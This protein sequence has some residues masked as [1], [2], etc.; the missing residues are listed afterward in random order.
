M[1]VVRDEKDGRRL[2]RRH[3][4]KVVGVLGILLE[5]TQKRL[6][7]DVL[8]NVDLLRK[9]AGFYVTDSVYMAIGQLAREL[10]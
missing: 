5:V 8:P 4:L 9:V 10:K 7:T 3:N 2:A 6:V 1:I